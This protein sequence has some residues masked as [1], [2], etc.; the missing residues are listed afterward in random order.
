M[1]VYITVHIY[2]LCP[3]TYIHCD[4][5]YVYVYMYMYIQHTTTYNTVCMY[6]VMYVCLYVYH[7]YY[8][9]CTYC[10][11]IGTTKRSCGSD[12]MCLTG[13][14]LSPDFSSIVVGD[15]CYCGPGSTGE[16]CETR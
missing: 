13:S 7:V 3:K 1:Y 8:V 10:A 2:L 16:H 11:Y 6:V 15:H 12:G 5:A 9:Y 4:T 14:T